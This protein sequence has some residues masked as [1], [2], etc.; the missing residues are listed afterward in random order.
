MSINTDIET[1]YT[2]STP[3]VEDADDRQLTGSCVSDS[4]EEN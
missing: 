3:T 2:P 1:E 4:C